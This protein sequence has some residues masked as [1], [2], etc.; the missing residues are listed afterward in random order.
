MGGNPI[1]LR[2]VIELPDPDEWADAIKAG[3]LKDNNV[4]IGDIICL[5]CDRGEGRFHNRNQK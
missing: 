3:K 5:S 1:R 4:V 2:E